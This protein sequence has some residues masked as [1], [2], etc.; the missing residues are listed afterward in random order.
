MCTRKSLRGGR[1]SRAGPP[2]FVLSPP[3]PTGCT[4]SIDDHRPNAQPVWQRQLEP[5]R[6]LTSDKSVEKRRYRRDH[7]HSGDRRP[8]GHHVRR[9]ILHDPPG[10]PIDGTPT[11]TWWTSP[12][13][14]GRTRVRSRVAAR[15]RT[16]HRTHHRLVPAASET[17]GAAAAH[18]VVY[19]RSARSAATNGA[20]PTSPTTGGCSVVAH[21]PGTRRGLLH[22]LRAAGTS[23]AIGAG[24][25]GAPTARSLRQRR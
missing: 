21:R 7:Q 14:G 4:P 19:P 25:V 16:Q 18:G 9:P 5:A 23:L 2:Q 22:H 24:L 3:P 17:G 1:A 11:C 20:V 15:Y 12:P 8:A 13:G 6:I 10:T